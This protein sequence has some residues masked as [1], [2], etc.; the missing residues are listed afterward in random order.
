MTVTR[1]GLAR[2]IHDFVAAFN[3]PEPDLDRVLAFFAEKLTG[4][5]A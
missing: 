1:T 5:S 3:E 4:S 2:T